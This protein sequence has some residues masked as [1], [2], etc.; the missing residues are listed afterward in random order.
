MFKFNNKEMNV[1]MKSFENQ[2]IEVP[3]YLILKDGVMLSSIQRQENDYNLT[4]INFEKY[5][6]KYKQHF[7]LIAN[8]IYSKI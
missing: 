2:T 1:L 5:F 4:I 6:E 7:E 3:Y 8:T